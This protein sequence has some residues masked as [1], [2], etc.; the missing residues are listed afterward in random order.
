[1]SLSL[2]LGLALTRNKGV[3]YCPEALALFARFTTPPTAQR[4]GQI[5]ALIVALKTAGVWAKL[6]ALHVLAAADAQAARQNWIQDLYNATAVSSPTFTADR[7][8]ASDGASSYVDTNFNPATAGSPKFVQNSAYAALWSRTSAPSASPGLWFDG[9][10]G[11]TINP[12]TAGNLMTWRINQGSADTTPAVVTDGAGLYSANRSG[13]ATTR[14]S[15]NGAQL[16]TSTT[17]ST[18]VN[19]NSLCY[20]R[21]SAATFVAFNFAAGVIGGS[22]TPTEDL[23]LY[24]ALLTY[25]QAV[26]AV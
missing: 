2:G 21:I 1:M 6:D 14:A 19:S 4:K 18:A 22:L 16:A 7:G 5:N 9:S 26:G 17:A 10:D 20:G 15:R 13:A 11:V 12:R 3:G 8:Y 24:N 23:A 25:M